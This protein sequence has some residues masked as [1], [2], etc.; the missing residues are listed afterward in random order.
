MPIFLSSLDVRFPYNVSDDV[1]RLTQIDHDKATNII[2]SY[3][4]KAQSPFNYIWNLFF[5]AASLMP[6]PCCAYIN[7]KQLLRNTAQTYFQHGRTSSTSSCPELGY[8]SQR[9][10]QGRST[11][12]GCLQAGPWKC[13]VQGDRMSLI[14]SLYNS[15]SRELQESTG[16][17]WQHTSICRRHQTFVWR[18]EGRVWREAML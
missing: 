13:T 15:G 6:M 9:H 1:N 8:S 7:V 11:D 14:E 10:C 5:I 18:R 2:K 3:A 12:S 17:V 16:N 4:S